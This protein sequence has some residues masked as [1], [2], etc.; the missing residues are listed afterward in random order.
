MLSV[1]EHLEL[2]TCIRTL[3][4]FDVVSYT[5]TAPV[6]MNGVADAFSNRTTS[7]AL[8]TCVRCQ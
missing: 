1:S 6:G 8:P 2:Q 3:L 5:V 4:H 7:Q